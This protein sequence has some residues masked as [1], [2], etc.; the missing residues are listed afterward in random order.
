[1]SESKYYKFLKG[2]DEDTPIGDFAKDVIE[3][4]NFPRHENSKK[5]IMNYL[6]ANGSSKECIEAFEESFKIFMKK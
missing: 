4:R 1:M 5:N 2:I 6:L 3:D